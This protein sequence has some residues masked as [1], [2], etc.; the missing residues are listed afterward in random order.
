MR[1]PYAAIAFSAVSVRLIEIFGITRN[2]N[3]LNSELIDH[4]AV[5]PRIPVVNSSLDIGFTV[6][7]NSSSCLSIKKN[8]VGRLTQ[9]KNNHHFSGVLNPLFDT[10][11]ISIATQSL[12]NVTI[13][14]S[15]FV[16]GPSCLYILAV[17]RKK[18]NRVR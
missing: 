7:S 9:A 6:K 16:E 13:L 10:Y 4:S 2:I 8:D 1:P 14:Q 5:Y 11:R 3:N 18:F 17:C 15:F 12:R